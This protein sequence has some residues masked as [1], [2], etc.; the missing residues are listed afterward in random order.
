MLVQKRNDGIKKLHPAIFGEET[1]GSNFC[2]ARL[3]D[4][5]IGPLVLAKKVRSGGGGGGR[6]GLRANKP[7]SL[8]SGSI[9]LDKSFYHDAPCK[10]LV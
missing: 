7:P 1:H 2:V 10:M 4:F 6:R 3:P 8:S 9:L 5:L